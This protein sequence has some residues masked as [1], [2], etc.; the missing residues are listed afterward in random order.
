VGTGSGLSQKGTRLP[1]MR[2]QCGEGIGDLGAV[3]IV[4]RGIP[5]EGYD[6]LGLLEL[7]SSGLASLNAH[8][9]VFAVSSTRV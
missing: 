3:D 7:R 1:K 5:L 6:R 9:S 4:P 8:M 2:E